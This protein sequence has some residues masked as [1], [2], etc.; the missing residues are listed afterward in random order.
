MAASDTTNNGTA[1]VDADKISGTAAKPSQRGYSRSDY[2]NK[3]K[4][5]VEDA[6][7]A[8]RDGSERI[9]AEVLHMGDD[10]RAIANRA[11][12]NVRHFFVAKKQEVTDASEAYTE[13]VRA[14]PIQATLLAAGV[15]FLLASF[16]RRR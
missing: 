6:K 2:G 16:L 15:G 7:Q 13:T 1:A 3:T 11:G 10:L 4:E 5:T 9:G 8:V 12:A 14:K